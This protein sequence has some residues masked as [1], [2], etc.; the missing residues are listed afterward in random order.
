M[1]NQLPQLHDLQGQ[2]QQ[3][4][5]PVTLHQ[6]TLFPPPSNYFCE[7][8]YLPQMHAGTITGTHIC[9]LVDCIFFLVSMLQSLLTKIAHLDG[10]E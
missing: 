10:G 2:P 1:Q 4:F 3:K 8:T 6:A 9:K 7:K 5:Q